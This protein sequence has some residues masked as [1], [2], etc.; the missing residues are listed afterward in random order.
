M[1]EIFAP[2]FASSL[3][4]ELEDKL[5]EEISE[6]DRRAEIFG[7]KMLRHPVWEMLLH[8]GCTEFDARPISVSSLCNFIHCPQ[9]TVLRYMRDLE[10]EGVLRL[11][12]DP[13]DRRRTFVFLTEETKQLL[14]EHFSQ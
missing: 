14:L 13:T 3:P 2:P 9:S 7:E 6:R 10:E 1:N 8:L 12:Q 4:L 5:R 11:Q